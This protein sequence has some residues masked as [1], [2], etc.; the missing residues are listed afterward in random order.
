MATEITIP[1]LE[2]AMTEGTLTEWLVD[3]GAQ[4]SEGDPIYTLETGKAAQ[5]IGAPASGQIKR[6]GEP[7]TEYPVGTVIGEIA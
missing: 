6:I 4:V 7:G 5:E 1:Q 2:M 3:D